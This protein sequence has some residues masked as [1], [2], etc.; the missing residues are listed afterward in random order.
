MVKPQK[1]NIC[2]F[3]HRKFDNASALTEHHLLPRS[4]G[5]TREHI[6]LFCRLCHS[7]VH[8]SF[9]NKTL[10]A[11]YT[12]VDALRAS[13]EMK[14]YLKWVR[15]QDPNSRFKTRTRKDKH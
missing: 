6:E 11:M 13:E 5:G 7:T 12:T 15:K 2:Q 1:E 8:A 10:A 14:P 3:C 9:E 4:K